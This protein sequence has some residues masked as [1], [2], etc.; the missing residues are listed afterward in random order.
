MTP[1]EIDGRPYRARPFHADVHL[2]LLLRLAPVFT[3]LLV[4]GPDMLGAKQRQAAAEVGSETGLVFLSDL[5]RP[6]TG[7]A[8]ALAAL[9]RSG[10]A[11]LVIAESMKAADQY[12][13]AENKWF[14]VMTAGGTISNQVANGDWLTKLRIT[15][16]VLRINFGAHLKT[17]GVDIDGF[18]G[19]PPN[20][21]TDDAV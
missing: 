7:T 12:V 15:I 10:D 16:A 14:A 8:E 1:F 20:G 3:S 13:E 6:N 18:L 4:A 5:L 17:I 11:K 2:S 9:D 21:A 19:S